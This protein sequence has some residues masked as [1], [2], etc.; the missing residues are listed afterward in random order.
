YRVL[1]TAYPFIATDIRNPINFI[2]EQSSEIKANVV[3][4]NAALLYQ[5]TPDL[6]LKVAGGIENRDERTDVYTTTKFFNSL[7]SANV[8]TGQ[9]T[10][11]LNENTLTYNKVFA[12]KHSINALV[13]FTYQDFLNTSLSGGGVGFLSDIF[14]T[15]DLGAAATPSVPSSNYIKS[16]LLSYLGRVNYNFDD[17]YLA[18]VSLRRD[19]SSRYSE[20][21]K[22]GYFPSAALAWRVSNEGF[23]NENELLSDLKVRTSWGLTGSQA[24]DP[25]QTLNQLNPGRTIFDDGFANTYSPGTRL[26]G[27]LKWETTEQF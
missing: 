8:S 4:A 27:D 25:Y 21:S 14:E 5:I 26:P 20:G 17:R 18:T 23:F 7:G 10:S 15:Y 1:S 9:F 19:G 22:W 24:I 3:L 12:E 13:G 2:N 6:L 11:L 16:V